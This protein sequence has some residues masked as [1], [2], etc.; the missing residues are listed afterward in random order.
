MEFSTAITLFC[1]LFAGGL[2]LALLANV[3]RGIQSASSWVRTPAH[4]KTFGVSEGVPGVIYEYAVNGTLHTS[5]AILPGPLF[6][7][8]AGPVA[9]PKATYL[10]PD[11]SLK[12]PPDA[13]VDA[14]YN[15]KNPA[16]AALVPGIPPGLWKGVALTLCFGLVP[17]VAITYKDWASQH[18]KELACG[19][20]FLAGI[21]LLGYGII[22]FQ[23]C[24]RMRNYPTVTGRLLKAEVVYLASSGDSGGGYMP[25][26]EY[27][28]RVEGKL[29]QSQQRTA[30]P[31]RV[32]T[33]KAAAQKKVDQLLS[34]LEIPVYYNPHAPWEAFLRPGPYGGLAIPLVMSFFFAGFALFML[35]SKH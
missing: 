18:V 16:D 17:Q 3:W 25:S 34:T 9:A 11:G 24:L 35:L 27:E 23:R 28:Y 4:I 1:G 31:I 19:F 7:K 22:L 2:T 30:L 21:F 32:L 10:N 33:G 5:K 12:F 14:Y 20:F 26:V 15:P 8:K 29:Y 6:S 13:V